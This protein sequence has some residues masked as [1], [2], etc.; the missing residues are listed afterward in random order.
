MCLLSVLD[1][2][3]V[4]AGT[5]VSNVTRHGEWNHLLGLDSG[6]AAVSSIVVAESPVVYSVTVVVSHERLTSLDAMEQLW[7]WVPLQSHCTHYTLDFLWV[8]PV[9]LKHVLHGH[10]ARED[11]HFVYAL[12][13]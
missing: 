3:R 2:I 13:A 1:S 7:V 8:P 6:L 5:L 9:L 4:P 12:S 10:V 11:H